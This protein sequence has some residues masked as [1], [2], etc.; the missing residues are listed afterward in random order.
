MASPRASTLALRA[1]ALYLQGQAASRTLNTGTRMWP[2]H[3]PRTEDTTALMTQNSADAEAPLLTLVLRVWQAG[4]PHR[5]FRLQATHVQTGD[6][7]Y[8]RT[9]DSAAQHMRCL[10]K[11]L[12]SDEAAQQPLQF[13]TP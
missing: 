13:P 9:L 7:A 4:P 3:V 1:Y 12:N 6:V 8:F 5:S 10:L 2:G 11:N